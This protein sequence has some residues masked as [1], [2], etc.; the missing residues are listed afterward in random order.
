MVPSSLAPISCHF[1]SVHVLSLGKRGS[2]LTVFLFLHSERGELPSMILYLIRH[3]QS[4]NNL[5]AEQ[6]LGRPGPSRFETYMKQRV[7]EPPLTEMGEKQADRLGAYVRGMAITRLYCSPML[8]TMQTIKPVAD[9]LDCQ[10]SVWIDLHEHGGIFL[11]SGAD[12]Q[13]VGFPGLNRAEMSSMFPGY[14]LDGIG[15]NGWWHGA[16][17]DRASCHARAVRV[18][19][20]LH[21]MAKASEEDEG[22]AAVSHGTFMDSLLKALIGRLPGNEFYFNHNNTGITRVDF[23]PSKTDGS[24]SVTVRYV[25]RT[26]HLAD[27]HT[28]Y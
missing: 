4:A 26:D 15:E 14:G 17:E 7:A 9:S 16:E 6:L 20:E 28:T 3:G 18:A 2:T 23:S 21:R 12:A 19:E 8:R 24:M 5:L 13:A 11:R 27:E 22:I 1:A 10:P 25:N